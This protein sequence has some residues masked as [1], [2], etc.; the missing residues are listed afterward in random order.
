MKEFNENPFAR[1]TPVRTFSNGCEAMDWHGNNCSNCLKYD[2]ESTSEEEA[3]CKFA[4]HLDIGFILGTIPLWV[5]K[6]IGIDYHNPLYQFGTFH[7]RCN[8]YEDETTKDL[9]F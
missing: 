8:H 3:K 5:C 9:P 1:D 6:E 7:S 2:A 4:Y